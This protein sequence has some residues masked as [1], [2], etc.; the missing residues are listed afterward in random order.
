MLKVVHLARLALAYRLTRATRLSYPP[1]QFTIEPTNACNLHCSFCPQSAP[2]HFSH[3]PVGY[4][5]IENFRLFLDRVLDSDTSNRNV[6]LTLDGEPFMNREFL[7]MI[8]LAIET[9]FFPIFATNGTLLGKKQAD[10]LIAAGPF[11]ASIDFASDSSIFETVRG[12]KGQ[13]ERLRTDI[14]HLMEM[15]KSN[16][17]IHLDIHDITPFAGI[18]PELSLARMRSLFPSDL[19]SRIRFGARQFHNFCGHLKT[20]R[21]S[22]RYRLCPYPWTQMAVTYSG[23]CVPCCRDTAGRSILGNL[24]EDS[25]M[26]IWNNNAYRSLRRNLIDRRPDLNAA[27]KDCDL[28]YSGGELRWKPAYMLRSLL[29][30]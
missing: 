1:Y 24:F 3:R 10:R 15:S 21:T 20:N 26:A 22:N 4:L 2:D 30:R 11:R 7:R 18:D 9:G 29:R 23:E 19:P 16:R 6:N 27:C 17:G 8:E 25:V 14:T 28:P 5:T 12:R 13:Y